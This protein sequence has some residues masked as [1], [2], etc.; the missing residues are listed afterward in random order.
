MALTLIQAAQQTTD[1]LLR[2]VI[3]TVLD[4][5]PVLQ[6]LPFETIQGNALKYTQEVTPGSAAFYAIGDTWTEG[7]ATTQQKTT[8]LAILG[9]D[10]DVDNFIQRVMSDQNDQ[11][12]TQIRLK[13][14]AVARQFETSFIQGDTSSD[15]NAFD[16]L[17]R[18]ITTGQT[19]DAATN[20]TALTLAL[21]DQMLDLVRGGKPDMLLMSR[22]SRRKLK[23]LIQA[24]AHYI[25]TGDQ[26]GRQVMHYDGIPVYISDYQPDTETMGS[27]GAVHSSI[28]ALKFGWGEAL[29]GVQNGGIEAVEVGQLETKDAMR[30][31]LRWYVSIAL[32]R[33]N[34]VARLRGINAS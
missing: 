8:N 28:Y 10:A 30:T 18:L 14:K 25:E 7:T 34:A 1:M 33:D 32:F 17:R 3:E 5:S 24:S 15:A 29:G 26:F 6:F 13:A 4:E 2:G 31:R 22:R 21:L 23:A 12:A 9:G 11:R 27:G 20:G 19:L 16:G